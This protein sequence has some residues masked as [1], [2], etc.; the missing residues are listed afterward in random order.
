MLANQKWGC[1]HCT[2]RS[3]RRWNIK[4]HIERIHGTGD[5]VERVKSAHEDTYGPAGSYK[6]N[7][8]NGT[9]NRSMR[10]TSSTSSTTAATNKISEAHKIRLGSATLDQY[11]RMSLET[12]E[13]RIKFKKIR[14]V[15][16]EIPFFLIERINAELFNFSSEPTSEPPIPPCGTFFQNKYTSSP[17]ESSTLKDSDVKGP[18]V[19]NKTIQEKPEGLTF[20]Q[21]RK[22]VPE[23]SFEQFMKI[24]P[25]TTFDQ[26]RKIV[27]GLGFEK[28]RKICQTPV[29]DREYSRKGWI[30]RNLFGECVYFDIYYP[31]HLH[32]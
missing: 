5:P 7:D 32:F 3:S 15:L 11:Y 30:R 28:Y 1:P 19:S 29:G 2:Q 13:N 12:E 9:F 20:D 10:G 27:P 22:I 8:N 25:G 26:F 31:Y 23:L 18:T 14:E 16:G 24:A 4:V 21:Y 6:T 17:V